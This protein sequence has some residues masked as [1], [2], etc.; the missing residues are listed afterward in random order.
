MFSWIPIHQE[1]AQRLLDFRER[2]PELIALLGEMQKAGLMTIR[3]TDKTADG[4]EIGLQEIDPF[5]FLANFNRG[6]RRENRVALWRFLHDRW[7]L[8]ASV[9]GDFEG[10]PVADMQKAWFMPWASER[11]PEHVGL[12]WELFAQAM[13]HGRVGLQKD[14]FDGCLKL[15]GLGVAYLSFGLFWVQPSEFLGADYKALDLA[16]ARGVTVTPKDFASYSAWLEAVRPHAPDGF[17]AFSREAH[18]QASRPHY[19]ISD[20]AFARLLERFQQRMPS[21]RNFAEPGELEASELNYK[22]KALAEFAQR[23]GIAGARAMVEA[24]EGQRLLAEFNK[25]AGN[26][27]NFR[28]WK[29]TFGNDD[30][31]SAR[32]LGVLLDVAAQPWTGAETL[33]PLFAAIDE[34][35]L[36][37]SWDALSAALWLLRPEDYFPVKIEDY[38]K[39]AQD[40]LQQ[41]LPGGRATPS[42]FASV[43]ALGEAFRERLA[44]FKPGDWTDVQSFIFVVCPKIEQSRS[45][46]SSL[47]VPFSDIFSS[48]EEADTIFGWFRRAM[49]RLGLTPNSGDDDRVALTVPVQSPSLMRFN[50]GNFVACSFLAPGAGENRLE[51]AC[52]AERKPSEAVEVGNFSQF[53]RKTGE[54]E[55]VLVRIPIALNDRSDV[56]EALDLTMDALRERFANWQGSPYRNSH[57]T[58]LFQMVFDEAYRSSVLATGL[59][60][61]PAESPITKDAPASND[62]ERAYTIEDALEDLFIDEPQLRTILATLRNKRNL[63]L[64]GAPGVGK[65]FIAERIAFASLGCADRSRVKTIQFHQSY[66]YEDFIQGWR[67]NEQGGFTLRNGHFYEFCRRAQADPTRDYVLIIDEINRGNLSRIFGELMV[68]LEPDKR[69]SGFA[70]PLT[71]SPDETFYVPE[72]LHI[73]G[74]MNTADRSLAMVDYA[75]RRRFAFIAIEP[76]FASANFERTLCQRGV[77]QELVNRIRARVHEVNRM[78]ADDAA[79]LGRGYVVGHSFFVPRNQ[80]EDGDAWYRAIIE[81][82]IL[83][84]LQEYWVDDPARLERVRSLLLD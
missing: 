9:P 21:F 73:I 66:G 39:L 25:R 23:P 62:P 56:V 10:L 26:L 14:T 84:L 43:R 55:F 32:L 19:K 16:K 60:T 37:P 65:S 78:I 76:S 12:L 72:R 75:L 50:F 30:A 18:L 3:L 41:T 77:S 71:Y 45:A 29:I 48:K 33:E 31:V 70:M 28:S 11:K 15:R 57:R 53:G 7:Q 8:S 13:Q 6:L 42:G 61:R 59:S 64:Q 4:A 38:R 52:L 1:T 17:P 35:E 69:G 46:S 49:E 74:L 67:P 81:W 20:T 47:G 63:I 54:P 58:E 22:R 36:K 82:E 44:V 2:Q 24:G 80:I 51:F 34:A 5:T 83:P 40:D 27:A 79:N 68:L